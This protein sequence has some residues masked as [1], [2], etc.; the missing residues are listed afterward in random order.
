MA[1]PPGLLCDRLVQ[2]RNEGAHSG[3]EGMVDR[4]FEFE[5]S[6]LKLEFAHFSSEFKIETRGVVQI[7]FDLFVCVCARKKNLV[8]LRIDQLLN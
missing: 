4:T 1:E 6:R 8:A 2:K 3:D 7:K 5:N